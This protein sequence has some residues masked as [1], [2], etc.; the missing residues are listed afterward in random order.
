M[1]LTIN[2]QL[3]ELVVHPVF[4][5]AIFSWLAAQFI[6]T[7]AALLL[8]KIKS[9]KELIAL[10][11][12]RTGGMP[13]SHSALVCSITTAIGYSAGFNSEV[14]ILSIC[15]SLVVI[16]DSV[17][18]RQATGLQAR[19]INEIG[20]T[21]QEKEII[22]YKKIKEV[23]GHKPLEVLIGC[24]LGLFIGIGFSVL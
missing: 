13:S 23:H 15:F 20:H 5:A 6:K 24:L 18:V 10:L 16:R 2:E 12:W 3:Q 1:S 11:L 9:F 4:L 8:G 7:V 14:F 17:G 21:L 19:T 22:E